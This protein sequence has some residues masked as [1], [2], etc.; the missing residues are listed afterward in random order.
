MLRWADPRWVLD[1]CVAASTTDQASAPSA[2]SELMGGCYRDTPAATRHAR[3]A[4]MAIPASPTRPSPDPAGG[5][6]VAELVRVLEGDH[7]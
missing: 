4:D 1:P 2:V 5:E 3:P 6:R 7:A